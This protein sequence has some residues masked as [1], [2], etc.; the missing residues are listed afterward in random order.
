[1]QYMAA[2]RRALKLHTKGDLW[3]P[4]SRYVR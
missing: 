1:L 3:P 4:H 2:W